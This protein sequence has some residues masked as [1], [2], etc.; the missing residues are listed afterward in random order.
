MLT[1]KHLR[2]R[3]TGSPF[4]RTVSGLMVLTALGQLTYLVSAPVLG[5]LYS[6]DAFGQ[7]GLFYTF[8]VTV[9]L[10][11]TLNY[12][13]AI[14][15]ARLDRDARRLAHLSQALATVIAPILGLIYF[16]MVHFGI[17]GFGVLPAWSALIVVAASY[18]QAMIQIM[19]AWSIRAQRTLDIGRSSISLNVS[20]GGAQICLGLANGP[21]WGLG[22]GELIGRAAAYF[23][24]Q[25]TTPWRPV[26]LRRLAGFPRRIAHRYRRFPLVILPAQALDGL[27]VLVQISGLTALFGAGGMGQYFLMRRTLDLPVA[28]VFRSLG[29][30]FYARMAEHARIAPALVSPFYVRSFVVLLIIGAAGAVPLMMFGPALFRLVFGSAWGG[31]GMLAAVMA[32]S[33]VMNL[34]VA[35]ASRV[36]ALTHRSLLRYVYT[37]CQAVGTAVVLLSAWRWDLT[38]VQVTAALSLAISLSYLAYFLAGLAA[39]RS[40]IQDHASE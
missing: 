5:R 2:A 38:L 19:Q 39:T 22:L 18:A 32:P 29:D 17:A 25:R 21:W 20:R 23:H 28:F 7:Y 3:I 34:A 24:L 33:A 16:V 36:F 15:A 12:E 37:V 35:P 8:L 40:L 31:A 9:A 6:P 11:P 27:V 4:A 13:L 10:F 1:L 26:Q 30:V 14:P